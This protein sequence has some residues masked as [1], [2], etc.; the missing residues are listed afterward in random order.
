MDPRSTLYYIAKCNRI[1]GNQILQ[2]A[3]YE[4]VP[5]TPE[6]MAAMFEDYV[7]TEGDVAIAAL[8]SIHP[9][10]ALF[11]TQPQPMLNANACEN[12]K[13]LNCEGC[14]KCAPAQTLSADSTGATT[15]ISL[16]PN[17]AL[18][19][20]NWN[21]LIIAGAGVLAFSILALVVVNINK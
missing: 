4:Y 13:M 9:D 2:K 5:L 18:K 7:N 10:K 16:D 20:K 6:E 21:T 14:T 1:G 8:A 11:E 15:T 3:G 12:Q 19:V 17:Q